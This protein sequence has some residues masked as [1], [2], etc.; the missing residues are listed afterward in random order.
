MTTTQPSVW[1][2]QFVPWQDCSDKRKDMLREAWTLGEL[3]YK[4]S[5]EQRIVYDGARRWSASPDRMGRTYVFDIARRFGKS[6]ILVLL[7]F[8]ECMRNPGWRWP[9]YAPKHKDLM[10]FIQEH[11]SKLL[12]DCPPDLMPKWTKSDSTYRF[13]NGSQIEF[14]GLDVN[15]DGARGG[16]V[17]GCSI[18]EGGF[19]DNLENIIQSVLVPQMM[20][21]P[22]ARIYAGSSPPISPSH[23]WSSAMVPKAVLEKACVT[24]TIDDSDIYTVEEKEEFIAELGGRKAARCRREL[25][26]EHVTDESLAIIPEFRDVEKEV[27]CVVE[28]PYFRDCYTVMDP[29]WNDHTASLFGYWHFAEA[30]LYVEDEI[31]APRMNSALIADLTKQK[32][33]V[34]WTGVLNHR[35]HRIQPRPQPYMRVSDNDPRLLYD[36]A[37]DHGLVFQATQKDN[38]DQQINAV[39]VAVSDKRIRIHPRCKMLRNQL[40]NGIWKNE[41][42]KVFARE[43]GDLGHF[44]L[45]AALVYLYRNAVTYSKGRNP[46]PREQKYIADMKIRGGNDG[47]GQTQS[48]WS[49]RNG[50]IFLKA[51]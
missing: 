34:L 36:L 8:E 30:F 2:T 13:H 41:A 3:S 40:K 32:E 24:R 1:R 48:K 16:G 51:K 43:G 45:I 50:R 9:Y 47:E 28:P 15:P 27:I 38:L 46:A 44:D 21:R 4:L 12:L 39:R 23:Y 42:R 37:H 11:L 25:F 5:P 6:S 10:K 20:G 49:R 35:G 29:G 26:T 31:S 19:F 14:T 33:A 17:D 22:W 18:D 7:P